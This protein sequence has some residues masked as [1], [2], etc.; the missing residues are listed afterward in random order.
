MFLKYQTLT[1]PYASLNSCSKHHT[2]S[3]WYILKMAQRMLPILTGQICAKH[4]LCK[5]DV[6]SC[7]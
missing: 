3:V 2:I 6:P 7:T 4:F 5:S 1:K